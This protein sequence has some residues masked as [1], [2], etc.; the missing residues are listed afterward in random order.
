MWKQINVINTKLE[1]G[2]RE[3]YSLPSALIAA[4]IKISGKIAANELAISESSDVSNKVSASPAHLKG[5]EIMS[6]VK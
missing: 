5:T 4:N 2:L 3:A 1:R 6:I